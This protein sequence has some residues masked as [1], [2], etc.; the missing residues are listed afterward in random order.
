MSSGRAESAT[1]K[2]VKMPMWHSPGSAV[3]SQTV[4]YTHLYVAEAAKRAID[5]HLARKKIRG[6][7]A[8]GRFPSTYKVEYD[9]RIKPLVS[10]LI[11]NKDHVEDLSRC[12]ESIYGKTTWPKFEVIVIENNSQDEATFR[13]YE[14]QQAAHA[15]LRVARYGGAFNFPPSIISAADRRR[16]SSWCCSTMISRSSRRTGSSRW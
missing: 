6:H 16:A 14:E 1:A 2:W 5:E 15:N 4:S 7:A 13:Y 8:D 12:L 10:I 11:P 3:A 9:L